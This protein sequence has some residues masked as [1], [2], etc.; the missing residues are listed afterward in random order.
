MHTHTILTPSQAPKLRGLAALLNSENATL[1]G[2]YSVST[3]NRSE[4]HSETDF[5]SK[6]WHRVVT[7]EYNRYGGPG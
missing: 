5:K 1:S 3:T 4:L 6:C 7:S 2:G